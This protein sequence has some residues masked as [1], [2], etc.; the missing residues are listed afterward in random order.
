MPAPQRAGVEHRVPTRVR[1]PTGPLTAD[2]RDGQPHGRRLSPQD[3]LQEL[4]RQIQVSTAAAYSMKNVG[5]F[6]DKKTNILLNSH[7]R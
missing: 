4:Q 3:A 6:V 1:H 7:R 5:V 2:T